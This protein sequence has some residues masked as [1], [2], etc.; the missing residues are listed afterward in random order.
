MT[1]YWAQHFL[2]CMKLLEHLHKHEYSKGLILN[3]IFVRSCAYLCVCVSHLLSIRLTWT[4][5]CRNDS[6]G[7]TRAGV[8]SSSP[9]EVSSEIWED[10]H[11]W[12]IICMLLACKSERRG[13]KG[14]RNINI[15]AKEWEEGRLRWKEGI[16]KEVETE[17]EEGR[18][19]VCLMLKEGE[20]E[21]RRRREIGSVWHWNQNKEMSI[22][23]ACRTGVKWKDVAQAWSWCVC[24]CAWVFYHLCVCERE[25]LFTSARPWFPRI[26]ATVP[27]GA[28][29][30]Y[31][32]TELVNDIKPERERE[33]R[34]SKCSLRIYEY[35]GGVFLQA[36]TLALVCDRVAAVFSG[37]QL[38]V[39]VVSITSE[40]L[41]GAGRSSFS[42]QLQRQVCV[43]RSDHAG[44]VIA[45]WPWPT[46]AQCP[47]TTRFNNPELF[48]RAHRMCLARLGR[49]NT[50]TQMPVCMLQCNCEQ[51]EAPWMD[52]EARERA[53]AIH[54]EMKNIILAA[55]SLIISNW[56]FECNIRIQEAYPLDYNSTKIPYNNPV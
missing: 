4:Q 24:K 6:D 31:I 53:A 9:L 47:H 1:T 46:L 25:C 45:M 5:R 19:S 16:L 55:G 37:G 27:H 17:E 13:R 22:M 41:T 26:V 30:N 44:L 20:S 51:E 2:Q 56:S 21:R 50:S 15:R 52:A 18:R 42:C 36:W 3:P 49:C 39:W 40:W 54:A 23:G 28:S 10:L 8:D 35:P 32:R 7:S 11:L 29:A 38:V 34:A 14:E 48:M 43:T 33:S 12:G